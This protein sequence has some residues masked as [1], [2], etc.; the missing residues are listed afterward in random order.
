MKTFE[1]FY[2]VEKGS[3]QYN[4]ISNNIVK[5]LKSVFAVNSLDGLDLADAAETY[6]RGIRL[7]DAV[8]RKSV[9]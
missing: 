6:L 4:A 5:N 3:E 7:S 9:V 2:G 8:D 1:N